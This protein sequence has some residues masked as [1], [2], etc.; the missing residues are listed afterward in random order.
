MFLHHAGAAGYAGHC[1]LLQFITAQT[2]IVHCFMKGTGYECKPGGTIEALQAY[3]DPNVRHL[4][5]S[6]KWSSQ[7]KSV[8][9][10]L[11]ALTLFSVFPP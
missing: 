1:R 8:Q 9:A 7:V 10:D 6:A 5:F 4:P 11:P 3:Y 2:V